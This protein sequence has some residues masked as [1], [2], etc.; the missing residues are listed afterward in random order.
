MYTTAR[1]PLASCTN[2][3]SCLVRPSA[4]RFTGVESGSNG[5]N[6]TTQPKRLGS[7]GSAAVTTQRSSFVAQLL[8]SP[9]MP[10]AAWSA[11]SSALYASLAPS[12]RK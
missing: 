5:S 12:T 8:R 3:A 6:S 7:F 10:Y 4:V 11:E 2:A 9:P 1:P